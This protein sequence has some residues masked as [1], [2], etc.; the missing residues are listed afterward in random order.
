M[1][2]LANLAICETSPE[3]ERRNAAQQ[4]AKLI[5]QVK[6]SEAG[7]EMTDA[8]IDAMLHKMHDATSAVESFGLPLDYID[9]LRA[10]VRAAIGGKS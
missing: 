7:G 4:L 5:S 10:I 2:S 9:E 8:Q 6:P 3:N 1:V